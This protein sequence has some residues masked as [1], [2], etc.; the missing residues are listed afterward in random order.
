MSAQVN[1]RY[2][3]QQ[4]QDP[5]KPSEA[6][7]LIVR[8]FGLGLLIYAVWVLAYGIAFG[9]GLMEE[10]SLGI[11]PYFLSGVVFLLLSIYLLRGAP[12]LVRFSY[13]EQ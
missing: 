10:R 4:D 9:F 2:P 1:R 5:M 11:G 7:A 6:F 12:H 13:P 8:V 3:I